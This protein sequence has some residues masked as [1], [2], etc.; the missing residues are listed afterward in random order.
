M[1]S[2]RL[3]KLPSDFSQRLIPF[4]DNHFTDPELKM[5]CNGF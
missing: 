1:V 2:D 3:M 5:C 4:K